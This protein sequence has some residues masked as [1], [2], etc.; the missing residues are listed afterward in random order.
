[1]RTENNCTAYIAEDGI[2][3]LDETACADYEAKQD[4]LYKKDIKNLLTYMSYGQLE[5][6]LSN[7]KMPP[8]KNIDLKSASYLDQLEDEIQDA[9]IICIRSFKRNT[10]K[11]LLKENS[12]IEDLIKE[13]LSKPEKEVS[14]FFRMNDIWVEDKSLITL[15]KQ[16]I[17]RLTNIRKIITNF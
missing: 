16:Y 15:G 12:S 14:I 11:P 2:I 5:C 17:D 13:A 8:I 4:K 3:F 10:N 9:D 6:N 1:M 7:I